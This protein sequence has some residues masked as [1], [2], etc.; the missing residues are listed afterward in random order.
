MKKNISFVVLFGILLISLISNVSAFSFIEKDNS[1]LLEMTYVSINPNEQWY[2]NDIFIG[3][4]PYIYLNSNGNLVKYQYRM[5]INDEY[6]NLITTDWIN[7]GENEIN[8]GYF[9]GPFNYNDKIYLMAR[10]YDGSSYSDWMNSDVYEV[11]NSVPYII[12][13][14]IYDSN[15]NVI[16]DNVPENQ[17]LNGVCGASDLDVDSYITNQTLTYTYNWVNNN[18]N[19][20]IYSSNNN[21]LPYQYTHSG[22]IITLQC[23]VS[24]GID[25]DTAGSSAIEITRPIFNIKSF[26]MR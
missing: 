11:K 12:V 3:S 5:V 25:S 17:N 7:Q 2:N 1:N 16:S 22:D 21:V 19:T 26:S 9:D 23:V 15:W 13:A 20:L 24:D 10:A 14:D 6:Q 18:D 4:S 8:V